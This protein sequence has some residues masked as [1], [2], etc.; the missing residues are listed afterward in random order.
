MGELLV[1]LGAGLI[2]GSIIMFLVCAIL[3]LRD[4]SDD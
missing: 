2:I 3:L 4:E 1:Y